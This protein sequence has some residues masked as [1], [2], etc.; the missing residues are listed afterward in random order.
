MLLKTLGLG[1]LRIT[2]A[3]AAVVY[4]QSRAM[5]EIP[6]YVIERQEDHF[7]VRAYPEL[8]LAQVT[9]ERKSRR[10]AVQSAF[11]PLARYIFT[12]DRP[13]EK[14]AM[15]APVMQ[16]AK[17]EGWVV[18]FIIP[19]GMDLK[20]LPIPA[21]SVRLVNQPARQVA[22]LLFSELRSVVRFEAAA[23][24][25]RDWIRSEGLKAERPLE[26]GYYDGPFTLPFLRRNGILV[27]VSVLQ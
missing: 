6:A 8:I 2:A 10:A 20:E 9:V 15:T 24:R 22:A 1:A 16:L 13:G 27:P 11:S 23:A 4:I 21:R 25:L 3:T 7:E 12:S 5:I 17:E 26:Y 14:I 18:S 19:A